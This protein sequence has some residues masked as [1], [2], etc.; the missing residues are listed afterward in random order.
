MPLPDNS[1]TS[2]DVESPAAPTLP[3]S[4]MTCS[5]DKALALAAVTS[6]R[7]MAAFLTA[8]MS[9]PRPSSV[10][11]KDTWLPRRSTSSRTCPVGGLASA[12]RSASVSKPCVTALRTT[13][14]SASR[15]D[16]NTFAS[17]RTSPPDASK[18]TRLPRVWA[19]SLTDRASDANTVCAGIRRSRCATSRISTKAPSRCSR[20][21]ARLR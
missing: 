6:P 15:S 10:H 13:C 21:T 3:S 19:A 20:S 12:F 9:M 5:A 18:S 1:V 14:M 4:A 11:T 7:V 17:R 8:S 2:L 16:A